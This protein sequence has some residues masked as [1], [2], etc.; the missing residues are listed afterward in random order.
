MM[1]T[2]LG[3]AVDSMDVSDVLPEQELL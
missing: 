3:W 2:A 1:S